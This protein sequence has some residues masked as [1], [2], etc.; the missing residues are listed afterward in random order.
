LGDINACFSEEG[1]SSAR[2]YQNLKPIKP[3]AVRQL[4]EFRHGS[5]FGKVMSPNSASSILLS[6]CS[7]PSMM[8]S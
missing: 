1:L 5:D 7:S 4:K 8:F 2:E 3:I 6:G